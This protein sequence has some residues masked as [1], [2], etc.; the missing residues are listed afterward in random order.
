MA[1]LEEQV[2]SLQVKKTATVADRR[3]YKQQLNETAANFPTK[4]HIEIIKKHLGIQGCS[5]RSILSSR[6]SFIMTPFLFF[7]LIRNKRPSALIG[8]YKSSKQ[9]SSSR[10][11]VSTLSGSVL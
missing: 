4:D 5:T 3:L 9:K 10:S 1:S 8:F 11:A 7:A 6:L 2:K